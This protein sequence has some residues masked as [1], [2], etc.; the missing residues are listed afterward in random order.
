MNHPYAVIM[1]GGSGTRFWPLSRG[2]SPKQLSHIVGSST[3]IQATVARLQP[4][5]PP[6]RV[7]VITTAALADETR[8]QLPMLRADHVIAEPIGRDTAACVC[9]A[10]T[11]VERIEPGATMI[12]TPADQVIE[13][14]DVFQQALAAGITLARQ[15]KLV[16]YGVAPRFAAT[17]YGYIKLG[18]P[19][20]TT[21]GTSAN[22]VE[23][24][25][26]KPDQATAERY[27][28]DGSY[29][30]NSGL[31]TWRSDI[32]LRELAEHCP[33]LTDALAPLAQAWGTPGFAAL[34]ARLYEPL[35]KISIDYA[36][37]E[38]ATNIVAV[39]GDFSWDDLGSWDSLYAHLDADA[40]GVIRRGDV[41]TLDCKDSLVLSHSPQT[42]VAIGVEGLSVVATHDAVLIV[43]KGRSQDVKKAVEALK[44]RGR[45]HLL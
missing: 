23:R 13:P 3:M 18:K 27:L 11:I 29:R 26:E 21:H 6:E 1:A 32:V 28:A 30:W 8:R 44:E 22:I 5:I 31:F 7:L 39:T 17:G 9:L 10:A 4:L 2:R 14:A 37:M 19:V 36:L 33:W 35:K 43:P 15:G 24:F 34:L 25:V 42:V 41:L 12:L 20:P 38:K 16:T 45:D 40:D